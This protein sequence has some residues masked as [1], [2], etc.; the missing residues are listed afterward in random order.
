MAASFKL[1]STGLLVEKLKSN[2]CPE[3]AANLLLYIIITKRK[4]GSEVLEWVL[5]KLRENFFVD[6]RKRTFNGFR[7]S[8][9]LKSLF[10]EQQFFE[11]VM[12]QI[13]KLLRRSELNIDTLKIVLESGLENIDY[14]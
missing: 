5:E 8:R 11:H 9:L 6:S 10:T 2:D 7:F 13:S 12:P 3:R 4:A 14:S 1:V